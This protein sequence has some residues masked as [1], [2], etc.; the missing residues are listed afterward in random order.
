MESGFGTEGVT[1]STTGVVV[2]GVASY[3]KHF[4]T[5][6]AHSVATNPEQ[7]SSVAVDPVTFWQEA[8]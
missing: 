3:Q 2:A 7:T 1:G 5:F 8:A 4:P 6:K